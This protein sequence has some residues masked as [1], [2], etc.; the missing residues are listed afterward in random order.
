MIIEYLV[1]FAIMLV[2]VIIYS[3]NNKKYAIATIPLL[4]LPGTNIL[5]YLFS[6][7]I[8]SI[9]PFEH[10]TVYTVMNLLAVMVSTLLVGIWSAKFKRRSTKIGYITMCL[11]FN[12]ILALIFVYNQYIIIYPR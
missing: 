2:L 4:V 10:I 9:I 1:I 6:D 3:K 5:A 7:P 12:V 11:L 8:A